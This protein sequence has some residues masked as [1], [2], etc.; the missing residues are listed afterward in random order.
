[1]KG[2][3][4]DGNIGDS[5]TSFPPWKH[6]TRSY[7]QSN[8]CWEKSSNELS[9]AYTQRKWENTHNEMSGKVE[10]DSCRKLHPQ[11]TAPHNQ[12]GTLNS[13]LLLEEWKVFIPLY[14]I[15]MFKAPIWGMDP[16]TTDSKAK[17]TCIP[18]SLRTISDKEAVLDGHRSMY[19][20]CLPR[21]WCRVSKQ[22]HTSS[23]ISL[24]KKMTL[25]FI[26]CC[27]WVYLLISMHLGAGCDSPWTPR[28]PVG[29]SPTSLFHL[30][31]TIKPGH[32]HLSWRNCFYGCR[33]RNGSQ[34][35]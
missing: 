19:H 31:P 4:Q 10:T 3:D 8:S 18:E 14:S 28:K 11:H 33:S 24:E 16:K 20:S 17:R 6:Q 7:T 9:D 15:I 26:T 29:N 30:T 13:Q 2:K 32:Q 23:S 12:Q 27:L 25:Y 35:T 5:W 21:A 1:M 34:I 22:K